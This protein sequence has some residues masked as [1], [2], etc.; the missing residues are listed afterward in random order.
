MSQSFLQ[1]KLAARAGMLGPL[2]FIATFTI[3]GFLRPGYDAQR[4]FISA[5]ALGPRGFIQVLNFLLSGAA[6]FVFSR[7][8]AAAFR[9]GKAARTGP[10]LLSIIAVGFFAS[11]PF[12]M[13]P[14]GTAREQMTAHGILHNLFGATVFSLAPVTCFLFWR[15]FRSDDGWRPLS[16]GSLVAG[17]VSTISV[18][19]MRIGAPPPPAP[20]NVLTNYIGLIQRAAIVP[21]LVWVFAVARVLHKRTALLQSGSPEGG[22]P[23]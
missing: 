8:V 5:L 2:L 23:A 4:M 1:T 14:M 16:T 10:V 11:G 22:G 21:F 3:E 19:L 15:R 7:G 18:V 6:L 20:G 17:I 13:D 12:V 9:E